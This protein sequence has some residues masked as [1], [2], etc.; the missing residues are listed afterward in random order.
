MT[1]PRVGISRCLLGFPVRYDGRDKFD[2]LLAETLAE[3]I[4]WVPV[5]PEM[6]F[7]LPVPREP[8]QLEGNPAS[9][10]LRGVDSRGD[11]TAA[12][13]A[14]SARRAAELGEL[15][16]FVFKRKSP[17][18]GLCVPVHAEDGS[19]CG[20]APGL[21]ASKWLLL[22]PGLPVAEAEELHDETRLRAFLDRLGLR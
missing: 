2:P 17:S 6:E 4:E 1:K 18:C 19:V 7:G 22:H 13:R 16:G 20:T 15:E 9:P 21:F 12:M 5:C 3:R 11:H 14:F 8:I 10:E